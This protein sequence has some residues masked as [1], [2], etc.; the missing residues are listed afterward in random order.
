MA[1]YGVA[2]TKTN[3]LRL[4]TER[5][6]VREG[7][8]LLEQKKDILVTELL[9]L[10]DRTRNA[11]EQ[12]D[13]VL[14]AAF[15]SLQ[16]AIVRMGREKVAETALAV[17]LESR[18]DISTRR[19]MGVGVPAVNISM[20]EPFPSYSPAET[21]F[22]ADEVT[23]RFRDVLKAPRIP[24]RDEGFLSPAGPRSQED[25]SQGQCP[26]KNRYPRPGRE[27]QVRFRR[28]R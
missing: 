4:R 15:E 18:L 22:W 3:L 24:C 6:F 19:V 8:Q 2:P 16:K 25:H 23:H 13:N 21:T 17:T 11:Q 5:S 7:H 26:G 1:R 20:S 28:F 27:S 9:A 14:L 12:M 10:M